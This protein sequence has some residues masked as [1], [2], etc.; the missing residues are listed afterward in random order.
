MV[1]EWK[2]IAKVMLWTTMFTGFALEY[3]HQ[4]LL[5]LL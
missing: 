5:Y 2:I 4:S 3:P 1:A